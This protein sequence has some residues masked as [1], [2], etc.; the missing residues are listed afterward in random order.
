MGYLARSLGRC[1]GADTTF[2][3]DVAS[4]KR[5]RAA[6]PLYFLLRYLS[7]GS[8]NFAYDI[9]PGE[10]DAI[11]EAGFKGLGFVQH[12]EY[13][14]WMA[15]AADGAVRGKAAAAHA[16]LVA[17][18]VGTDIIVDM[19]GLG[20]PGAPAEAFLTEWL[21]PVQDAGFNAGGGVEYEGYDDGILNMQVR[22]RLYDS[23]V[24]K[25]VFSDFGHREPLPG[26]GFVMVQHPQTMIAGIEVDLDEARP[27]D[28]GSELLFMCVDNGDPMA[29]DPGDPVIE[30]AT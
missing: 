11:F 17:A 21:K 4:A 7:L 1:S 12:V 13:P 10:R 14:H 18:P 28:D 16:K 6:N 15:G 5:L 23:G 27:A 25:K 3:F 22:Q 20:N 26:V 2:K 30:P 9:S 29:P 19:E 24:V 8:P